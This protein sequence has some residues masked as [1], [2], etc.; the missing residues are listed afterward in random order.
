M[1][2]RQAANGRAS[3]GGSSGDGLPDLVASSGSSDE[4]GDAAPEARAPPRGGLVRLPR[5]GAKCPAT[6]WVGTVAALRRHHRKATDEGDARLA[7]NLAPMIAVAAAMAEPEPT[8]TYLQAARAA[9]LYDV[10]QT[11]TSRVSR[12]H[13]N[14]SMRIQKNLEL[15][16]ESQFTSLPQSK[17]GRSRGSSLIHDEDV[18]EL[19]RNVISAFDGE[20]AAK[21]FREKV[22]AE[23]TARG[24]MTAGKRLA[25]STTSFWLRQLDM[26]LVCAKKGACPS[27]LA[28]VVGHWDICISGRRHTFAHKHHH[29]H[30]LG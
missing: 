5:R 14:R 11:G 17:Q 24:L 7:R 10:A 18:K 15:Y 26:E 2:R 23:L 27:S 25:K 12:K 9:A 21:D 22:S 8:Q 16:I 19:C 20:F 30:H 29:H 3:N 13:K 4:G 6:D 28:R 1:F